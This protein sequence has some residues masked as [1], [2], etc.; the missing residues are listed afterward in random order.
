MQSSATSQ[1]VYPE[2][3]SRSLKEETRTAHEL[4][5]SLPLSADIVSPNLTRLRYAQYLMAMHRVVCD[6]EK[7]ILPGLLDVI[8]DAELRAK[9]HLI[10][11]D[12][13]TMDVEIPNGTPLFKTPA[14]VAFAL[15][16]FYVVEGSS[17][18][19]RFI[20][21]NVRQVLGD[22]GTSYFEGYGNLSGQRW[23]A[24]VSNLDAFAADQGKR[25]E[26]IDGANYAFSVIHDHFKSVGPC[27]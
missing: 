9:L 14:S 27:A 20:L 22:V 3:F 1:L 21:Q 17:L 13:K 12:L 19:G 24:F 6:L 11:S 15:G 25:A 4:L 18:G 10:E 8:P 26:I 7:N 2:S 23:K 16:I 5:E